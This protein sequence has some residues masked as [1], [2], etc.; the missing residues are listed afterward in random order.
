MA[1]LG[2]PILT[3]PFEDVD[4][5]AQVFDLVMSFHTLEHMRFPVDVVGELPEYCGRMARS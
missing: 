4:F 3:Q 2:V 1:K 5:G